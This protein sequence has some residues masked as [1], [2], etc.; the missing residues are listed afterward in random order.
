MAALRAPAIL[1]VCTLSLPALRASVARADEEAA[2]GEQEAAAAVAFPDERFGPRY[3][4][5]EVLVKGNHKTE[6][7][8]I[9]AEVAALGLGQGAAVDASDPRVQA[10]RYRLLALG[11]FLDVRLSVTRGASRGGVVLVVEV[12]ERGTIVINELFPSTSAATAFWGGADAS[13]TNFLGRGINLGAGF[14]ASTTPNVEGAHRGLGL[15]VR[16][17]APPIGGPYGLSLSATGLY[18]DGSEFFRVGGDED[19]SNPQNFIASRVKRAGGVLGVGKDFRSRVHA[20]LDI[21]E[22]AISAQLPTPTAPPI[23]FMI[24]PA[25]SRLGTVTASIDLDTRSD[26]ILPRSGMRVALSLEAATGLLGS[27]YDYVKT[28][29]EGSFYRPMPWGGHALGFH[30]L[31]GGIAGDAPYFDRFF[32]GDL[33]LLL[34]RRALGINFST[35]PSRNLLDT[36][37]AHHRYDQYAGRLLVE[38]AIPIWRRRGFVYGGDGFLAVGLLGMA[39]PGDVQPAGQ[40][41]L[42]SL[43]IDLTGDLGIRLDTY[44]GIFTISIANALSRTSF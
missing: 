1:L 2:P 16:A 36:S 19:D 20:G 12:E 4:I 43:P 42:Q 21:R 31:A 44:I 5:D 39:S 22:E 23:D 18:N 17:V 7:S 27:S 10:A 29:I 9:V 6:K 30:V 32:I 37:I 11:Y 26:P 40:T 8:I 24:K 13:E 3:V 14:V 34:P 41:G 38:Y 25:T 35:L 33:N 15:R 28:L